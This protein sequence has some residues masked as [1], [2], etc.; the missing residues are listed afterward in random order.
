MYRS[1]AYLSGDSAAAYRLC[2]ADR[3]LASKSEIPLGGRAAQNGTE[4]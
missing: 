4:R 3:R 1:H 2:F